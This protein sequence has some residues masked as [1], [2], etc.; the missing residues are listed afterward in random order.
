MIVVN[1]KG[2]IC[3]EIDRKIV[4]RDYKKMNILKFMR[5]VV[6]EL[7]KVEENG[8]NEMAKDAISAIVK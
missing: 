7:G 1:W 8:N 2:K 3:K 6:S 5:L 4:R